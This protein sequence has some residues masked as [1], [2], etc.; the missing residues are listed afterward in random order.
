MG[1]PLDQQVSP[2]DAVEAAGVHPAVLVH[3]EVG[4]GR[5]E[6]GVV[7]RG[8]DVVVPGIEDLPRGQGFEDRIG[9]VDVLPKAGTGVEEVHAR[10]G[11]DALVK[12]RATAVVPDIIDAEHE[13]GNPEELG[14]CELRFGDPDSGLGGG[15]DQRPGVGESQGGGEAD[16][17]GEVRRL[18]RRRLQLHVSRKQRSVW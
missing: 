10:L 3:P 16:R 8:L 2:L 11:H 18:Q 6:Q 9:Q 14:P 5:L 1:D 15:H 4:V 17:E 12:V 7:L 13:R